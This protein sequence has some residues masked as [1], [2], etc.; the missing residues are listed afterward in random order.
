MHRGNSQETRLGACA[1]LA[2]CAGLLIVPAASPAWGQVSVTTYHND[3]LRTGWNSAE[4]V[5]TAASVSGGSFNMQH[6]VPLDDQVDAQPLYVANQII[7]GQSGPHNVVYVATES[8]SVYAIDAETGVVLLNR[9]LGLPVPA[10]S[11]PG[12]CPNAGP[13]VGIN[14]TPVISTLDNTMWVVSYNYERF[15]RPAAAHL[16]YPVFKLHALDLGT[17]ADKVTPIVIEASAT[18]E[19]GSSYKFDASVSRQRAALL[20]Q[21]RS[22]YAAFGSFCDVSAGIS[23]GWLLR[24]NADTLAPYVSNYL[25]DKNPNSPNNFYLTSIWMSGY[26]PATTNHGP[27]AAPHALG[28]P[29][30][31]VTGNSDYPDGAVDRRT[32]FAESLIRMAPDLSVMDY[33]TPFN[34]VKLDHDDTDFGSGG[35]MLLPDGRGPTPHVAVAAGKDGNMFLVNRDH[36]GGYLPNRPGGGSGQGLILTE[37]AGADHPTLPA[38]MALVGW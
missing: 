35:V 17:L 13:N 36:L 32:H 34:A 12:R 20:Y 26:G 23:R 8:N 6:S 7:L 19:D 21:A 16:W 2:R 11:L 4:T 30:Y 22:I 1:V 31:F 27:S 3:V 24:W 9:S 18:L 29:I 38:P 5:L 37:G 14:S 25:T 15:E 33:F 28:D 10:S